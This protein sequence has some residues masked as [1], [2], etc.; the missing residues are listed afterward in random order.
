M[1]CR[2]FEDCWNE[3]LDARSPAGPAMDPG[4]EA[5]ASA[6]ERCRAISSGYQ[7]LRQA[8]SS[9]PSPPAASARSLERLYALTVPSAPPVLARRNLKRY[10]V[11]L[12]SAA[13]VF[14]LVWL[15]GFGRTQRPLPVSPSKPEVVAARPLGAAL[16]EATE[17]TID[18]AREASAP[19]ARIGREVLEFEEAAVSARPSKPDAAEEVAS[20]ASEMLQTVGE[21][22]N[23]GV[24]PI[25]GSARHAFGFL[26]GPA[27]DPNA[28][29]P[30]SQNSL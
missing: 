15:G 26:L 6:C 10:W 28:A 7:V 19:A 14:A 4:L 27:P 20:T 12:A 18:L 11:P 2:E 30:A 25:S 21:Q 8:V 3:L 16:A 17:A 13:A 23:A 29:H 9:W 5:H 1:D 24:R 22:V